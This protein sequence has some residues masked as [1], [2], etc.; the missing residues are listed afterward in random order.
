MN[1]KQP[2]EGISSKEWQ[3]T[4]ESV[5]QLVMNLLTR[6]EQLQQDVAH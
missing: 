5:R 4:P 3:A 6:L 2:P 1:G